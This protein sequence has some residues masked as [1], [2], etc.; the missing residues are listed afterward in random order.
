MVHKH[1]RNYTP[2]HFFLKSGKGF[3]LMELLVVTAILVLVT[4]LMLANNRHFGGRILL[5]NLAYDIALS[6]R[7]AQV[8]GIS[9]RQ[10]E[11]GTFE[12]AYGAYFNSLSTRTYD[13]FGD[14]DANG[15]WDAGEDVPPSPYDIERGHYI[16]QL[17]APAGGDSATC[18]QASRLAIVFKRPEPDACIGINGNSAITGEYKCTNGQDSARIVL[19]SPR[20]DEVSVVVER[21]GQISVQ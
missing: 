20:G 9:V 1:V 3:T 16:A 4:G 19:R 21:T 12:I 18:T 2:Y 7:Q 17:C 15:L 10:F 13:L 14:V 6:V 11:T 5:E 8:Y